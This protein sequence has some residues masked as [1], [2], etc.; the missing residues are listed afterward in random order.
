MPTARRSAATGP[1]DGNEADPGRAP[2]GGDGVDPDSRPRADRALV[3]G[4]GA[5]QHCK[6]GLSVAVP[7]S[8]TT[9]IAGTGL[10]SRSRCHRPIHKRCFEAGYFLNIT[11]NYILYRQGRALAKREFY[12]KV[13]R[14]A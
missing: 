5:D 9:A 3:D 7:S 10:G 12:K 8:E 6:A 11:Y 14:A 13:E 2:V 4:D 1:V